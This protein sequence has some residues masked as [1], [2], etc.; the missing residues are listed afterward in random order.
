MKSCT[1]T[2]VESGNE[3]V[4]IKIYPNP[5][6]DMAIISG[7]DPSEELLTIRITNHYGQNPMTPASTGISGNR[8]LIRGMKSWPTGI[9]FVTVVAQSRSYAIRFMKI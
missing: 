4:P 9:Y 5:V 1:T 6:Q 2:S 3:S 8:L 7:I